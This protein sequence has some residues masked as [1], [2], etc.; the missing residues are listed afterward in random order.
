MDNKEVFEKNGFRFQYNEEKPPRHRMSLTALPHSGARDGKRAV[1]FGK[2]DVSAL[3]A[4]LG[5]GGGTVF[6]DDSMDFGTS[7]GTGEDGSGM[8]G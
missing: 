8:Y 3:C 6:E 1:N 2:E 5:A 4:M 7:G